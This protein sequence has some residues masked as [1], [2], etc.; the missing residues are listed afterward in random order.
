MKIENINKAKELICEI[1]TCEKQLALMDEIRFNLSQDSTATM[2]VNAS[3]PDSL[4]RN[5]RADLFFYENEFVI[6]IR[7]SMAKLRDRIK[8]INIELEKL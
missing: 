1:E 5:L 4:N 7:R 3:I 6:I 8:D 2:Y